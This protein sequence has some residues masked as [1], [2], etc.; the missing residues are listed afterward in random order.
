MDLKSVMIFAQ[1]ASTTCTTIWQK[2]FVLQTA[3]KIKELPADNVR[4]GFI[5]THS[6][7]FL[8]SNI[9]AVVYAC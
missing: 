4:V 9:Q 3:V 7:T 8:S 1:C 5:P 2:Y 6:S